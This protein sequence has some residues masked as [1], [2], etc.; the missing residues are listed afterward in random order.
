MDFD[1]VP[2]WEKVTCPVLAF[3]GELDW[4]VP[5]EPNR[6]ALENA[7]S[8]AG[9]KDYTIVVLPKAN[10][11][12]LKAETGVQTEYPQLKNFIPAYFDSMKDWLSTRIK[13]R[14]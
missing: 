8:K 4:T 13:V 11:L 1:S 3:F 14:R 5:P 12:F 2:L 7:L 9:N 6:K 10:H